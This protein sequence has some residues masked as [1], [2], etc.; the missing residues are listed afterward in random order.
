[1][2]IIITNGCD[3]AEKELLNNWAAEY[4]KRAIEDHKTAEII[5]H[6]D[7]SVTTDKIKDGA[8]ITDKIAN[9]AV[10]ETKLGN[11]AVTTDKLKDGSV[12]R[13][14]IA[15]NAVSNL[16]IADQ[17]VNSRNIVDSAITTDKIGYGA[18]T[19]TKLADGAVT[20]DKIAGSSVTEIKLADS[21]VTSDKIADNAVN[22]SKLADGA[23]KSE[24]IQQNAVMNSHILNG[25][26]TSDKL[27]I[28][29]VNNNRIVN[30]SVDT[31]TLADGAVT[32]EKTTFRNYTSN[33]VTVGTWIDGSAI[34][35]QTFKI[36]YDPNCDQ[37]SLLSSKSGAMCIGVDEHVD[38]LENVKGIVNAYCEL[39][40]ETFPVGDVVPRY[41]SSTIDSDLIFDLTLMNQSVLRI[42]KD[43]QEEGEGVYLQGY[44]EYIY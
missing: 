4:N 19:E 22:S 10:T 17:S 40:R 39:Y 6:P 36:P 35:R 43:A 42:L 33:P 25:A 34:R 44:I 3:C 7:G 1:M 8:V 27:A 18:V 38:S 9:A 2:S 12:T 28:G 26:V 13:D 24:S 21:A 31:R 41:D 16:N 14:K 32:P 30:G 15:S 29:S 23:V 37:V 20:A 5:D 11:S